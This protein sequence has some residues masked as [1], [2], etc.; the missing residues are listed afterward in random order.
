M[1]L[2]YSRFNFCWSDTVYTL[3]D[4]SIPTDLTSETG[5][6]VTTENVYDFLVEHYRHQVIS[7]RGLDNETMFVVQNDGRAG[8]GFTEVARADIAVADNFSVYGSYVETDYFDDDVYADLNPRLAIFSPATGNS[9]VDNQYTFMVGGDIDD[10]GDILGYPDFVIDVS[11]NV[12][13]GT[14]PT[15]S[16]K[17]SVAGMFYMSSMNMVMSDGSVVEITADEPTIVFSYETTTPNIYFISGNVGIGESEPTELLH[18]NLSQRQKSDDVSE[19][20][21]DVD[22]FIVFDFNNSIICF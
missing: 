1:K 2:M 9:N 8:V 6:A 5:A 15:L 11:G 20:Y 19:G 7:L 16:Y 21:E 3:A 14:T 18:I 22:P 17:L 10:N 4:I 13:I 12:G